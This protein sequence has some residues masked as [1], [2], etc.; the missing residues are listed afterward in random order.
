[1]TTS[2]RLNGVLALVYA[3]AAFIAPRQTLAQECLDHTKDNSWSLIGV[4]TEPIRSL[5][6]IRD[7]V[8]SVEHPDVLWKGSGYVF[9]LMQSKLN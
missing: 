1:M 7:G 8:Y 3:L 4:K 6:D 9:I 5:D 2:K